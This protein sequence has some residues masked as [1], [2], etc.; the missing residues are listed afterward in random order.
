[1]AM[2]LTVTLATASDLPVLLE[3]MVDFNRLELIQWSPATGR[4]ALER[5]LGDA[6][7]GVVGLARDGAEVA[8][9]FVLT[10]GYDLEWN[11]RD[12]LLTELY[13]REGRR[14]HG[15]ARALLD[16]IEGIAKSHG[17]QVMHML[18]RPENM[19]ARRLYETNGFRVSPRLYLTKD[20]RRRR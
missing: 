8:G 2:A 3:M 17:A 5:L 9:Y 14:G 20:F 11:G 18:V 10:W 15:Q 16:E 6:A 19:V 1:M 7:L 13:L 12:A 4:A